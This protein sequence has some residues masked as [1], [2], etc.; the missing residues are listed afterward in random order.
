MMMHREE[1]S[2]EKIL[3]K[4]EFYAQFIERVRQNV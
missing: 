1:I 4:E 3:S 2:G